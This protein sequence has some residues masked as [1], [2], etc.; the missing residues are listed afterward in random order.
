MIQGQVDPRVEVFAVLNHFY[1][2]FGLGT[3]VL[4]AEKS[5]A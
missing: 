3:G 5:V 2:R 1:L 4:E